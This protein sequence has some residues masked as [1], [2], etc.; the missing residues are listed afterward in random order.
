[1]LLNSE[2]Q[3]PSAKPVVHKNTTAQ[4]CVNCGH[5][6]FTPLL[7]GYDFDTAK[8][9]FDLEKCDACHLTRTSPVLNEAE[10]GPYYDIGYY[11]SSVK[12]FNSE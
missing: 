7:N 12:K 5:S 2:N 6:S 4:V 11:G 3:D 10:L 9:Q 8:K 1:M